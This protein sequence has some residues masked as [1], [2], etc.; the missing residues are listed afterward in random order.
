[1]VDDVDKLRTLSEIALPDRR[2]RGFAVLNLRTGEKRPK[3]LEDHY[4]RIKEYTLNEAVPKEIQTHFE[5][6][7]N[8]LL[9]SWFVHNF[10]AVAEMQSF[11][12]MEFALR[13]RLKSVVGERAGLR[14]FIEEA[15]KSGIIRD[16][17]FRHY[18]HL[19]QQSM[20]YIEIMEELTG[21]DL[22]NYK[23]IDPQRYCRVLAETMPSLRNDLA[24]GSRT[25]SDGVYLTFSLC[26]DLINQLFPSPPKGNGASV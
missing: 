15:I 26:R 2:Q 6:A 24:H 13:E 4:S 11:A 25:L 7:K 3:T 16:S 12:S 19:Q 8:L 18:A 5:V 10:I 9:Y 17:D 14:R 21:A 20:E 23:S 1:M 22:S